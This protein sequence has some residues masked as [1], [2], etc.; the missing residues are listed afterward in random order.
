[1][2]ERKKI[3]ARICKFVE[4]LKSCS[5][6]GSNVEVRKL[7]VIEELLHMVRLQNISESRADNVSK[8]ITCH[9]NVKL[10]KNGRICSLGNNLMADALPKHSTIM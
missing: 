9:R 3:Q 8:P 4:N 6:I 5:C 10:K 2:P 1:M 7:Y